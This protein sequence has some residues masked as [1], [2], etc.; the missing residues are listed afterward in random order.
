MA[1]QKTEQHKVAKGEEGLFHVEMEIPNYDNYTGEKL[2]KSWVHKANPKDFAMFITPDGAGVPLYAVLGFKMN[3]VI[4]VPNEK[5]LE[6]VRVEAKSKEF[7][8]ISEMLTINEDFMKA[9]KRG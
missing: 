1:H 5:A 9:K 2:S 8:P 4:H 3:R 7:I 6:G